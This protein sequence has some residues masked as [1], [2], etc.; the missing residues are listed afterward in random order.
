MKVLERL[1][2]NER[3]KAT[4]APL[5]R[6]ELE[7]LRDNIL[8]EEGFLSPILFHLSESGDEVIVDGHHRYQIWLDDGEMHTLECPP[9]REVVELSGASEE[10]VVQWIRKHQAG[11]RNDP[12]LAEQ[13]ELGKEV[14]EARE[15]GIT[16]AEF[17]AENELTPSQARHAAQLAEKIDEAEEASPGFKDQILGD[18][19]MSVAAAKKAAEVAIKPD[20][21]P[22]MAFEAL[23]KSLKSLSRST[24]L[25]IDAFPD[26]GDSSDFQGKINVLFAT[27]KEWEDKCIE[28]SDAEVS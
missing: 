7:Q 3:Y 2:I 8:S 9:T 15:K 1:K 20:A 25:V 27:L 21:E 5:G 4:L 11:R 23:Q 10:E 14:V 18:E 13:Y 12:T 22:L 6:N 17:V 16:S 24:Q 26:V 28:F 19:S